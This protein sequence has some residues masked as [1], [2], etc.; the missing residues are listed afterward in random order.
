MGT[1]AAFKSPLPACG[2]RS[3]GIE[4]AIRVRGTIRESE[5]LESPPH[6]D[7]F[8]ASGAREKRNY[9]S[10]PFVMLAFFSAAARAVIQPARNALSSDGVLVL[11]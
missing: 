11:P 6:P 2:E 1:P 3:D 5:C 8:P 7:P 4:D 9:S 10:N